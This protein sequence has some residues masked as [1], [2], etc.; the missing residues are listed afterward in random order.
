MEVFKIYGD[1]NYWSIYY[2]ENI[3]INIKEKWYLARN[4]ISVVK[5]WEK[6][7][8]YCRKGLRLCRGYEDDFYQ[9]W[10]QVNLL[11]ILC[12]KKQRQPDDRGTVLRCPA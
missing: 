12:S 6:A 8:D 9:G 11:A 2:K 3:D 10:L 1:Q 4:G 7:E 5:E